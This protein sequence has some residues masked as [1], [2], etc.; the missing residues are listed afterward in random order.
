VK[1]CREP[2]RASF[3]NASVLC[4][5]PVESSDTGEFNTGLHFGWLP[6]SKNR[7]LEN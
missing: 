4:I 3:S 7:Q 1:F 5:L 6:G 2:N